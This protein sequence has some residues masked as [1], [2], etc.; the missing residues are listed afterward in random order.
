MVLLQSA[1]RVYGAHFR[2]IAPAGYTAAPLEK[3]L[4]RWQAVG[5]AVSDLIGQD[6]N[7]TPP[8]PQTNMLPL[9]QVADIL[10][11]LGSSKP[12]STKLSGNKQ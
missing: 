12:R 3:M 2:P 8:A 4:Q 9:D 6:L 7:L 1:Y 11:N 5:N 10:L